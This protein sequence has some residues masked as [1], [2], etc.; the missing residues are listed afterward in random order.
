MATSQTTQGLQAFSSQPKAV[1]GNRTMYREPG[2][3]DMTMFRD[4]KETCI[5]WDKRVHRGNTYGMYTRNAIKEALQEAVA[6]PKSHGPPRAR[7]G[8]EKSIFHMP[9]PEL[10]RVAVD[11]EK[12][13]VAREEYEIVKMCPVEAQT[14][15]FLPEV[16][17]EQYLPQKTGVDQHTQVED[18]ELFHFDDEVEPIL[19]VLVNK[20]L[21]QSIM[22][23][24]EEHE[25]TNMSDFKGEWYKRQEVMSA[26]WQEQVAEEW[27]RWHSKEAVMTQKREE[28]RREAQVLLKIQAIAAAK[29]H[30][31]RLVPNAVGDLAEVAFPDIKGMAINRL[32]L[33]QLFG[34]VQ[35]EVHSWI[36]SESVVDEIVAAHVNQRI[37]AQ[38]QALQEQRGRHQEIERARKEELQIRHGKIRILVDDGSGGKLSVGPVQVSQDQEIEEVHA[39]IFEW[40]QENEPKL[41]ELWCWGVTLLL[42]GDPIKN[43]LGIFNAKSGQISMSPK[44]EPAPGVDAN[45][46]E[47][48]EE[49]GVGADGDGTA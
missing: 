41:A 42:D 23:V 6:P 30:L 37:E 16:P 3:T 11:L 15:E 33:P 26:D 46:D 13:L 44:S 19:D 24:E 22:E 25:M 38:G 28:K 31:A 40:L 34:Q 1:S 18:G 7:R 32:F 48:G 14:D 29:G 39:R 35:Q 17:K 10:E 21:E 5:S 20:T 12:H 43:T 2:T 27:V 45:A 9:V 36:R 4:L 49:G 8:K 47:N